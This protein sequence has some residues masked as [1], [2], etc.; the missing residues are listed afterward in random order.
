[1]LELKNISFEVHDEEPEKEILHDIGVT[2][3][4]DTLAVITRPNGGG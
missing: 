3:K 4:A 2:V 1:M